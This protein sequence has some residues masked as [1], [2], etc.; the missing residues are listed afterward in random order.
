MSSK[1][2]INSHTRRVAMRRPLS[3]AAR[4]V[5]GFAFA[6]FALL[7]T[8]CCVLY[9]GLDRNLDKEDNQYLG[10]KIATIASVLRADPLHLEALR[11]EVE[12]ESQQHYYPPV[13]IRVLDQKGSLLAETHSMEQ[14]LPRGMF[15][16]AILF[17][18]RPLATEEKESTEGRP[19]DLYTAE[20]RCAPDAAYIVQIALDQSQE[21][22]LLIEYRRV[23]WIV[24]GVGL[25]GAS[26]LSYLI[27]RRGLRPIYGMAVKVRAIGSENLDARL[28]TTGIPAELATLAESFNDMLLRLEGAFNRLSQFSADIAHELRTPINNIRGLV[29][30]A[31]SSTAPAAERERL[32]AASLEESQRLSR[33]IDDLLFLA[34]AENPQTQL[35]L[36]PVDIARELV[37]L[38]EFYEAAGR[39]MNVSIELGPHDSMEIH[40]DRVLLQRAIGN[41]IE[42][43]LAH[44]PGGGRVQLACKACGGEVHV[45]VADTGEGIPAEHIPLVFDRFHRVD[46][47]RS[48]ASG[49]MGLGLALVEG[50]TK[51]HGA[52]VELHSQVGA[53]STF[54]LIFPRQ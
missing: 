6:A 46:P 36:Q 15:P 54:T 49:G 28:D 7:L 2:A 5:A 40:A 42:N 13:L 20:I 29:E 27:V 38:Q 26:F 22:R 50:I 4:L 30:V 23:L 25:I 52:R 43:A 1:T 41:L 10:D 37:R 51:L 3:L 32:L 21:E 31:L 16:S 47:S 35:K 53:G 17:G 33:L 11:E 24:L 8:A 39:E 14:L 48:K 45:I 18:S 19:F 9:W 12:R 34:R 44:T